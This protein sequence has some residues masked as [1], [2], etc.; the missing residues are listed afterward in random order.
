M[1]AINHN[2]NI[3]IHL[4]NKAN[5]RRTKALLRKARRA[6]QKRGITV[7]TVVAYR[8]IGNKEYQRVCVL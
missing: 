2:G 8:P 3:S 7:K 5:K 4:G 1:R 6:A